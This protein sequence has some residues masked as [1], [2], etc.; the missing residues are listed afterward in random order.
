MKTR[1]TGKVSVII[2][3]FNRLRYVK[4]AIHSVL[5]QTVA[6]RE[7]IVVDDASSPVFRQELESLSQLDEGI[8]VHLLP[9]HCGVSA[10][11]NFGLEHASGEY[12]LFLDDDDVIHP[13]MIERN[14]AILDAD[15]SV[16][17]VTCKI[18]VFDDRGDGVSL[19]MTASQLD[20]LGRTRKNRPFGFLDEQRIER[21]PFSHILLQGLQINA[22]LTRARSIAHVRFSENLAGAGEDSFFWLELASRGLTFKLNNQLLSYVRRHRNSAVT[23]PD[24][25]MRYT[26]CL[27][28][29]LE[30]SMIQTRYDRFLCH[31]RLF[32]RFIMKGQLRCLR[33]GRVV[34]LSPDLL[35]RH[36]FRFFGPRLLRKYV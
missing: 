28:E 33:H 24:Y 1:E 11:R 17:V 21:Q 30:S 31:L 16:D 26:R 29:I 7:I 10:A 15:P 20:E 8:S 6:V 12:I 14:S 22:N 25:D 32:K 13:E 2:P 9:R 36:F 5:S 18:A 34:L 3:T 19:P 23:M 35:V 4:E 27:Y